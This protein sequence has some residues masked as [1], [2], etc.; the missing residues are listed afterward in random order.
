M[1]LITVPGVFRPRSDSRL[2]ARLAEERVGSRPGVR[3][4]EPCTGS[5]IVAV[6]AARAGASEVTAIDVSRRA[7]ACARLNAMLNGVSI[8]GLRGDLLE[9]VRGER[10]DLIVSNPPYL[11]S[12]DLAPPRGAARAWEAGEDGRVVLDRL[13][14]EAPEFLAPGGELLVI[15]SSVCGVEPTLRVLAAGGLEAEVVHSERGGLG[16][17]L[18]G[19]AET[20]ESRGMLARGQREEEIVVVA[21]RAPRAKRFPSE[22]HMS[23]VVG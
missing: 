18:A 6:S 5:G 23:A 20:L 1:R 15:H 10:F 9:P 3:V 2:L 7:V 4:L 22:S 11:P 8:R 21:A 13:C 12:E 16:P 14:A 17:L 19:R